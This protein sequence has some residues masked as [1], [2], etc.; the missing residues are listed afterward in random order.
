MDLNQT[1]WD[2]RYQ[3]N[4]TGWD[5]G[6]PSPALVQY[7]ENF[8]FDTPILIPG[9]GRAH[10]AIFL[11]NH[12]FTNITVCDLAPTPLLQI[13]RREK[14]NPIQLIQ[15]NFFDLNSTYDLIL[16]QT[17]FCAISPSLRSDYVRKMHELL[18]KEGIIAGVLFASYFDFD[19]PPFG[20]NMEEYHSLF[21]NHFEI[22]H[23]EPCYNSIPPRQGN[24]LF[25][26]LRKK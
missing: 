24:E 6:I 18:N 19:G 12:G 13:E 3:N 16:E 4:T 2:Q 21:K 26:E 7:A 11:S 22:L 17:F 23:M 20:G 25:I 14:R 1:Y 5:T 15:G 8:S 9:A 10:E